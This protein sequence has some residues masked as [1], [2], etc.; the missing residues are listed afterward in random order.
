ME[1]VWGVECG[2]RQCVEWVGVE[3]VGVCVRCVCVWDVRRAMEGEFLSDLSVN[4]GMGRSEQLQ[5]R[6]RRRRTKIVRVRL[7]R[8]VCLLLLLLLV[9]H[10]AILLIEPPLSSGRDLLRGCDF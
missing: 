7:A 9:L 4:G 5:R 10:L 8:L 3:C 2:M 1:K 6:R